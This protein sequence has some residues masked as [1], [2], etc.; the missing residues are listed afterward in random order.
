MRGSFI[1]VFDL[2]ILFFEFGGGLSRFVERDF[3][4]C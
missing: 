2:R 1:L 3:F 4:C